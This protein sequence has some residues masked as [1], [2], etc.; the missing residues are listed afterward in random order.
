VDDL[1][2]HVL[3]VEEDNVDR[4]AHEERV[5][6]SDRTEEKPFVR[7]EPAAPEQAAEPRP[8]GIGKPTPLTDDVALL[9]LHGDRTSAHE[10][11]IA[12]QSPKSPQP[13]GGMRPN[14]RTFRP[15]AALVYTFNTGHSKSLKRRRALPATR[16]EGR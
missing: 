13:K 6:R 12:V 9:P 3:E 11:T 14:L 4:K 10:T 15:R 7:I 2:D 1:D 5:N 16:R 8:R